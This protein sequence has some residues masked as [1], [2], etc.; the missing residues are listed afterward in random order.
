MFLESF[1]ILVIGQVGGEQTGEAIW[2]H[3]KV[4]YHR[5]ENKKCLFSVVYHG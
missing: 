2:E 3:T 5:R 4:E 1:L